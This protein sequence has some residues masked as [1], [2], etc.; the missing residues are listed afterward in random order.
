MGKKLRVSHWNRV[1]K[2]KRKKI[3]KQTKVFLILW[4]MK[5]RLLLLQSKMIKK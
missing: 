2:I 1:K 3:K 4:M 5:K